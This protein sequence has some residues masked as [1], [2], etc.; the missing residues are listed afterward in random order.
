MA[1][2]VV[3]LGSMS[4]THG[5]NGVG[6]GGGSDGSSD[7]GGGGG[8]GSG[9]GGGDIPRMMFSTGVIDTSEW[10]QWNTCKCETAR[11]GILQG[12]AQK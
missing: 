11:T 7:G 4:S 12:C 1:I 5:S 10:R 2:A 8:S 9:S 6:G 3:E